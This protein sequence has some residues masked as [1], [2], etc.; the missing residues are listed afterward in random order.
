MKQNESESRQTD[1]KFQNIPLVEIAASKT[2]PR[3]AFAEEA[4]ND[5][6]ESVRREGILVPL[7]VR[8]DGGIYE[9]IDGERRFKAAAIVGLKEVPCF[10]LDVQDNDVRTKQIIFNLQ[11]AD[12]HPME[13]A[14]AFLQLYTPVGNTTRSIAERIGKPE[15]YVAERMQ[16]LKLSSDAKKLYK[17]NILT[18]AHAT[19]LCKMTNDDQARALRFL[20]H[21]DVEGGKRFSDTV[22]VKT[23]VDVRLFRA[24]IDEEINLNLDH[25]IWGQTDDTL[26]PG[27]PACTACPKNS[28]F[29]T[30]LFPEAAKNAV[31]Y[32]R[33]CFKAKLE[34]HK[35]RMH[36]QSRKDEKRPFILI[37]TE[38]GLDMDDPMKIK[39][40]KFR[41]R[42]KVVKAGNEC[43]NTKKAQWIDGKDQGKFTL[44]CNYSKCPKHWKG[45]GLQSTPRAGSFD[46]AKEKEKREKAQAEV[47]RMRAVHLVQH[48]EIVKVLLTKIPKKVTPEVLRTVMLSEDYNQ[49]V[50]QDG[51]PTKIMG[52]KGYV[53]KKIGSMSEADLVK[54]AILQ[55]IGEVLDPEST[56]EHDGERL[57]EVATRFGVDVKSIR[58]AT[59]KKL[60]EAAKASAKSDSKQPAKAKAGKKGKR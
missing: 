32:D 34:A 49:W 8:P 38:R 28:A 29:N 24:W 26:I 33:K 20:V 22:R 11:R 12:L 47:E 7:V 60:E 55:E 50:G 58:K 14:E 3:K 54:L 13:E 18:L 31:C 27:V 21:E 42:F 17:E 36:K 5:L 2:N 41:E 30:A 40:V 23:A 45:N 53:D 1:V 19:L 6:G 48:E 52:L 51:L 46:S 43:E 15:S 44:V 4:M 9:I 37:S 16:L 39:D 57:D 59:L 25:A 10:I 56:N 35:V